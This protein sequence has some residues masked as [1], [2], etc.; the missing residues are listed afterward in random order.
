[1]FNVFP[2]NF[3][4]HQEFVNARRGVVG[5]T[6]LR[7]I[8]PKTENLSI[9]LWEIIPNPEPYPQVC[10]GSNLNLKSHPQFV[11]RPNFT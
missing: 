5:S 6:R 2:G 3:K 8:K 9:N 4:D 7:G 1:M 10:L 11:G